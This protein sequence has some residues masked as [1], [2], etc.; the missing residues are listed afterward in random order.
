MFLSNLLFD[1]VEGLARVVVLFVFVVL[2]D[3]V[4]WII[5][6]DPSPDRSEVPDGVVKVREELDRA[7]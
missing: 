6:E 1:V 7:S 3:P 5:T 4:L 2:D